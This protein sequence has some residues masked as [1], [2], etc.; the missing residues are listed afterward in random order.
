NTT[1]FRTKSH[2]I[3]VAVFSLLDSEENADQVAISVTET[4][5]PSHLHECVRGARQSSI[6]TNGQSFHGVATRELVSSDHNLPHGARTE[7]R[8]F[9]IVAIDDANEF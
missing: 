3:R 7:V 8:S 9:L 4:E 5:P 2:E 6:V 1:L